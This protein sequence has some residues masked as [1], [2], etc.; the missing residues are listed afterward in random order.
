MKNTQQI[1]REKA[2]TNTLILESRFLAR[3][4]ITRALRPDGTLDWK[5]L[6]KLVGV[7]RKLAKE[8]EDDP[9]LSAGIPL[10]SAYDSGYNVCAGMTLGC[11]NMCLDYAGHG[12]VH[13]V[14][15]G[16]HHVRVARITRTILFF[17]YRDQ[18]KVQLLKE[19]GAFKRRAARKGYKTA[20]RP[21][22]LSDM[23][24]PVL[25]PEIFQQG[26]DKVYDYTKVNKRVRTTNRDEYHL[27]VSRHEC[28]TDEDI[29][30]IM[31]HA[32]VAVVFD[33]LK[34]QP[35]P[36]RYLGYRVHDGDLTDNR[37]NDPDGYI[38]GLREKKTGKIDHSGFVVRD[39]STESCTV[40][41]TTKLG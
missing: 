6:P 7:N 22:I 32:N 27:T 26:L 9:Y 34:G 38:I 3:T 10:A 25:M 21:N 2:D 16:V 37:F 12:Q 23:D 29:H 13:M 31:K 36:T 5:L 17:E 19:I 1:I 30:A 40:L 18:F 20:F 15:N 39:F 28:M 35:L 11:A 14:N 4:K 41:T 33:T 24:W 8:D